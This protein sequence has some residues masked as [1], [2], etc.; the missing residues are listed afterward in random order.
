MCA[1]MSLEAGMATELVDSVRFGHIFDE[2]FPRNRV[3]LA[4]PHNTNH[5]A[6]EEW[7]ES[8]KLNECT[9]FIFLKDILVW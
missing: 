7:F 4:N 2:I 8:T 3:R 9:Q 5:W 6:R 1:F